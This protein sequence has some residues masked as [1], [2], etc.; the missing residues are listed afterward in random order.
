MTKRSPVAQATHAGQKAGDKGHHECKTPCGE[1][2][3]TRTPRRAAAP[4][5]WR[6]P[7]VNPRSAE[8]L[9]RFERAAKAARGAQ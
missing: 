6:T 4:D 1:K 9:L 5:G 3:D 7:V 2:Q 8:V